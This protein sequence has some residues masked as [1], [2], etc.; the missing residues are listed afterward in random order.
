MVLDR[1][2]AL[3]VATRRRLP[4]AG[5][6]VQEPDQHD[7]GGD[8]VVEAVEVELAADVRR[9]PGG[10]AGQDLHRA[11]RAGGGDPA[12]LP[13]GL[14][15][16]DR[17]REVRV[18]PVL[19]RD[20]ATTTR[21]T[22]AWLTSASCQ[23]WRDAGRVR[24]VRRVAA[25]RFVCGRA[26][27][28]GAGACWWRL[29]G[30]GHDDRDPDPLA[31]VQRA[32]PAEVVERAQLAGPGVVA[33]RQAG[34]GVAGADGVH[35]RCGGR[36]A[37]PA[38][39][40]R[41]D[42]EHGRSVSAP[43]RGLGARLGDAVGRGAPSTR[44]RRRPWSRSRPPWHRRSQR[45]VSGARR[46]KSPAGSLRRWSAVREPATEWP[47]AMVRPSASVASGCDGSN[48]CDPW[49]RR[50]SRGGWV[51][52]RLDADVRRWHGGQSDGRPAAAR[53]GRRSAAGG[54]SGAGRPRPRQ[55]RSRSSSCASAR[56][57]DR[58]PGRSTRLVTSRGS[59]R[60]S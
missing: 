57:T 30:R 43:G 20:L 53:P 42:G 52:S 60:R 14:L 8:V 4:P 51:S 48:D 37:G 24:P 13:A 46:G 29:A 58:I 39:R 19:A 34:G 49:D 6:A 56:T 18:D 22:L 26:S 25:C 32:V 21:R 9:H 12:L 10:R 7:A 1:P 47:A 41:R 55:L 11:D 23:G 31:D 54:G 59:R 17:E 16:G 50:G 36:V 40:R 38:G 27:R 2:E 28:R 35:A 33:D 15:P 3:V 5:P 44:R 45:R